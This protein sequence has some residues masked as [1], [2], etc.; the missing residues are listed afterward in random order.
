[1]RLCEEHLEGLAGRQLAGMS[2]SA[3]AGRSA[4]AVQPATAAAAGAVAL[5]ANSSSC[6]LSS[7]I[8]ASL[9]CRYK[10]KSGDKSKAMARGVRRADLAEAD[11][12]SIERCS[13]Y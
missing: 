5:T 8:S 7:S 2:Q 12:Q 6:L 11:A 4:M 13:A 3:P 9:S 1:M 10:Y